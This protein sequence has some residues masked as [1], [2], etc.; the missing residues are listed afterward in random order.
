MID[1]VEA[2]NP[3][4]IAPGQPEWEGE[5]TEAWNADTAQFKSAV[6]GYRAGAAWLIWRSDS[7]DANTLA[8]V[9]AKYT[10]VRFRADPAE[11]IQHL[12]DV[13]GWR[14]DESIRPKSYLDGFRLLRAITIVE[15]GQLP[16]FKD[17]QIVEGMRRAGVA[18]IPPTKWRKLYGAIG[19]GVA[20]AGGVAPAVVQWLA[21]YASAVE[22]FKNPWLSLAFHAVGVVGGGLAVFASVRTYMRQER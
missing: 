22:Q 10:S 18:D 3:L 5:C 6:W 9:M 15:N 12:A 20:I 19:G 4:A 13:T 11:Y 1:L 17:W 21:P 7:P 8:G 16:P 14:L 2:C